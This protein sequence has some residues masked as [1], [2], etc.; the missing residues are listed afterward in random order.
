MNMAGPDRQRKR[1]LMV[2]DHEDTWEMVSLQ[3]PEYKFIFTR[4]FD[5]GLRLARRGYFDIYILDNWLPRGSGIGLCRLIREFDPHTPIL[6]YSAAAYER[7]IQEAL[8]SGAQAYLAKPVSINDFEQAV[9]RL[10]S[11]VARR[12]SEAWRAEIAAIR[13]ELDIRY[14][15]QVGLMESAKEKRLRAE[16]KLMRLKAEKAFLDAGGTRGELA[17]RW[18][19]VLTGEVRGHRARRA[20]ST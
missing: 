12:D 9:A 18:P 17:R 3:L 8:R 6:F 10:T 5:E 11:H 20:T 14:Q 7:D 4:D 1:I 19:S 13:G 16:E 2:E 15:E